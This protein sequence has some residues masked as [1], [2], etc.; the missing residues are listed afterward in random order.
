MIPGTTKN[1]VPKN[2]N[3]NGK[4]PA[5]NIFQALVRIKFAFGKT[6]VNFCVFTLKAS[7]NIGKN[8]KCPN[9]IEIKLTDNI[10]GTK[11]GKITVVKILKNIKIVGSTKMN[12]MTTIKMR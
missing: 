10:K 3:K 6:K 7:I 1:K 4:I 8:I 12:G 2:V 5:I 9:N 11:L